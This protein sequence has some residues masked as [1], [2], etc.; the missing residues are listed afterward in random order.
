MRRDVAPQLPMLVTS[1]QNGQKETE[2]QNKDIQL[3]TVSDPTKARDVK[4]NKQLQTAYQNVPTAKIISSNEALQWDNIMKSNEGN[5]K[6]IKEGDSTEN[7][8]SLKKCEESSGNVHEECK[9]LTKEININPQNKMSGMSPDGDGYEES[10]GPW[11]NSKFLSNKPLHYMAPG[12]LQNDGYVK[13]V[14]GTSLVYNPSNDITINGNTKVD[15]DENGL[16][17]A[18]ITTDVV[19]VK[20]FQKTQ[21]DALN[22]KLYQEPG[23]AVIRLPKAIST[24]TNLQ[25]HPAKVDAGRNDYREDLISMKET[26]NKNIK[27]TTVTDE[28][29]EKNGELKV[30]IPVKM[31]EFQHADESSHVQEEEKLS[32][33]EHGSALTPYDLVPALMTGKSNEEMTVLV[34]GG[35]VSQWTQNQEI[36]QSENRWL[37]SSEG[38]EPGNESLREEVQHAGEKERF[39]H[40]E[41]M[42]RNEI[43][44][45]KIP[46]ES[47]K[48][49]LVKGK[50]S[51]EEGKQERVPDV[52]E[53]LFAN[54]VSFQSL[55]NDMASKQTSSVNSKINSDSYDATATE[56]SDS[57]V[58]IVMKKLP[59]NDVVKGNIHSN[60][61]R[62][63][64]NVPNSSHALKLNLKNVHDKVMKAEDEIFKITDNI[65]DSRSAQQSSV[66]GD[67]DNHGLTQIVNKDPKQFKI[68]NGEQKQHHML[69]A[70]GDLKNIPYSMKGNVA[71][72][73]HEKETDGTNGKLENFA[74][75]YIADDEDVSAALVRSAKHTGHL[76]P[77]LPRREKSHIHHVNKANDHTRLHPYA[78]AKTGHIKAELEKKHL[79]RLHALTAQRAKLKEDLL[80][81]RALSAEGKL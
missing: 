37:H 54:T 66:D 57:Q 28:E 5:N 14:T 60:I 22:M 79:E 34:P 8:I 1:A 73:S 9:E 31:A 33:A 15:A 53:N 64:K 41:T 19:G 38:R 47:G 62:I 20:K 18:N 71:V 7:Y 81:I 2:V 51:S 40:E 52:V 61:D 24:H 63:G 55:S 6:Q 25:H 12:Q 43:K 42:Q 21:D 74:K 46:L 76:T 16:R 65:R 80:K 48:Q 70:E 27:N 29:V 10:K 3:E 17:M 44:N 56:P 32:K 59:V 26:L 35:N 72:S 68:R 50:I 75:N 23:T 78:L 49:R 30:D 4:E 77:I 58:G 11:K 13:Q 69:G 67:P 36:N 45:V 39:S